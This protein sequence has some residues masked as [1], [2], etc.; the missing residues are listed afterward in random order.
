VQHPPDGDEA[1]AGRLPVP[2]HF[3]NEA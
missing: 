1:V 3:V 2:A